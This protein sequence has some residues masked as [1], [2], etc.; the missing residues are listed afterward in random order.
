[1]PNCLLAKNEDEKLI[2]F[3]ILTPRV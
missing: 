2:N 3:K 1:M